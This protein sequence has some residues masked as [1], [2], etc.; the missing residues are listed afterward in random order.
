MSSN[1]P[2]Y[3]NQDMEAL[4]SENNLS[5]MVYKGTNLYESH[6]Y[7]DFDL[8]NLNESERVGFLPTAEGTIHIYVDGLHV[9]EVKSYFSANQPVWGVVDVNGTCTNVKS[10]VLTC[11]F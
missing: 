5:G 4:V 10:E 2:D 3:A 6:R 1:K 8:P 7:L 11:E 9:K